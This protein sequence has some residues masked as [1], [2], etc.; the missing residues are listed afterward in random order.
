MMEATF[1]QESQG[2]NRST[3][4]EPDRLKISSRLAARGLLSGTDTARLRATRAVTAPSEVSAPKRVIE[5]P[6][7]NMGGAFRLLQLWQGFITS[8]AEG[9]FVATISDQTNPDFPEEE[10]TISLE[11]VD[12]D[13]RP[14]VRPGAVFYWSIG[15]A[16]RPGRPRVRESRIRMR[17]LQP[18][19]RAAIGRARQEGARLASIF[20]TD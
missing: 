10:V 4:Q 15:Y 3:P 13:D 1:I 2:D 11:E 5:A 9:E 12:S 6:L 20:R 14:L 16:D 17:R 8:V 19:T 7:S 18:W